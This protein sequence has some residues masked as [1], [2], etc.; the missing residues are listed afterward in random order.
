MAEMQVALSTIDKAQKENTRA[1]MTGIEDGEGSTQH[2]YDAV[3]KLFTISR[4]WDDE[5]R[6]C[7]KVD[8]A[9]AEP[10]QTGARIRSRTYFPV[11]AMCKDYMAEALTN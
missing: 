9:D 8:W 3:Y 2:L 1:H 10:E 7:G 5:T 11:E 6:A 4:G